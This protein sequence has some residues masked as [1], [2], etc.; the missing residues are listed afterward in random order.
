MVI[1]VLICTVYEVNT[2]VSIED[3]SIIYSYNTQKL[4]AVK[5]K[6]EASWLVVEK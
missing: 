5:T 1:Y 6:N 3:E 2:H 4:L